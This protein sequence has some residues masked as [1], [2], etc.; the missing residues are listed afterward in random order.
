MAI[1]GVPKKTI[2]TASIKKLHLA[3]FALSTATVSNCY[4]H[5]LYLIDLHNL[6]DIWAIGLRCIL[7]GWDS[8]QRCCFM[9]HLWVQLSSST[10]ALV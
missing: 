8:T 5:R 2:S 10:A 4:L 3:I 1:G 6:G 7:P 9:L